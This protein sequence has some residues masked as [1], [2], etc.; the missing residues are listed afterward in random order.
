[1][2]NVLQVE[3]DSGKRA[4]FPLERRFALPAMD[5]Q[6]AAQAAYEQLG[7]FILDGLPPSSEFGLDTLL[8]R[9]DRFK[10]SGP[11]FPSLRFD[12]G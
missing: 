7:F 4:P 2:F 11:S 5:A 3:R 6:R 8:W 1:M 12:P 9:T 10:V